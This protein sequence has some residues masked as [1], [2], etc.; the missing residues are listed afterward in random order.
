MPFATLKDRAAAESL[1]ATL[2]EQMPDGDTR[3]PIARFFGLHPVPD[4]CR[5]WYTGTIGELA[6]ARALGTLPAGWLVL[7]SVP[8]GNRGSDIDHVVVAP[9]GRVITITLGRR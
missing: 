3:G 1:F 6:V 2:R 5:S 9:D 8:V 7:H 4:S